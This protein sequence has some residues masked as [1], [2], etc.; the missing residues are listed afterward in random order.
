MAAAVAAASD[1]ITKREKKSTSSHY[2]RLLLLY[3]LVLSLLKQRAMKPH[4]CLSQGQQ[5][6]PD[7]SQG[8]ETSH[9]LLLSTFALCVCLF[10]SLL[11]FY[12]LS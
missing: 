9:P 10:G 8:Q 3:S 6:S 12:K 4:P 11:F 7:A 5:T 2:C 1:A